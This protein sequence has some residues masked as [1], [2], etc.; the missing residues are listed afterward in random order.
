MAWH[1]RIHLIFAKYVAK[2]THLYYIIIVVHYYAIIIKALRSIIRECCA[3]LLA[4]WQFATFC[5]ITANPVFSTRSRSPS[6]LK[7]SEDVQGNRT[8]SRRAGKWRVRERKH[9][10]SFSQMHSEC[11]FPKCIVMPNSMIP[12]KCCRLGSEFDC[13]VTPF[14]Q[15]YQGPACAGRAFNET[16]AIGVCTGMFTKEIVTLALPLMLGLVVD[17]RFE[18]FITMFSRLILGW[19]SS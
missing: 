17:V 12:Y 2:K 10:G 14:L 16:V 5:L 13:R 11:R 4:Q 18:I 6:H 3:C 9:L 7:Y 1:L 8:R 19:C 15:N